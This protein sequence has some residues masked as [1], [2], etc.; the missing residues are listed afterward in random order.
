MTPTATHSLVSRVPIPLVR[1]LEQ[2]VLE[3]RVLPLAVR[4]AVQLVQL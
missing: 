1:E 2:R 4:S 3:Q